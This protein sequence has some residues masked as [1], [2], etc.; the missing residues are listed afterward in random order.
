MRIDF[1]SPIQFGDELTAQRYSEQCRRALEQQQAKGVR[2]A[3]APGVSV[4]T[5]S[6]IRLG[7][8]T[9]VTLA[10]MAGFEV[11]ATQRIRQ[12]VEQGYILQSDGFNDGPAAA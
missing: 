9:P 12:L 11:S 2:W 10:M 7:A 4:A 3:V 8:G 1:K 5:A 6:G